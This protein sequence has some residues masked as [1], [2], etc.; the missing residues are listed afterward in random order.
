M[1]NPFHQG[2]LAVQARA[3]VSTQAQSV[4]RIITPH[5]PHGADNFLANLPILFQGGLDT[6]GQVWA[7]ALTGNPGFIHA[8]DAQ[9]VQIQANPQHTDPLQQHAKP[10][11]S[12]GFLAIDLATRQRFRFNGHATRTDNTLRI[13]INQAYGNCPKYIQRRQVTTH[14]PGS[15]TSQL[16]SPTTTDTTLS[17]QDIKLIQHADTFF[18]ATT[19]TGNKPAHTPGVIPGG[20]GTS[21][22]ASGGAS[23][24]GSGGASGGDVSHRGGTPGFVRINP[25]GT[26]TFKDY[27]G[28]N[29]FQTLGNL[30]ADP[31]AGLLFIDFN[32]GSTLQLTGQAHTTW[33]TPSPQDFT[34]TGRTVAF[35]PQQILRTP[36]AI[37]LRWAFKDYSPYNPEQ[38]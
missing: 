37:N 8:I 17:K 2:E 6:L 12:T 35:H 29:M 16:P 3:G 38:K 9:T 1:P 27:P 25:Q 30:D 5:L 28:N 22:G 15:A 23:G 10:N 20:G 26:L 34:D 14:A 19:A 4:G 31:R 32:T 18:I 21:G 11:S 13:Q 24:G 33:T 7:S 36:H